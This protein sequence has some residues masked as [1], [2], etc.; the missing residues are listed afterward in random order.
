[1]NM[2]VQFATAVSRF[3]ARLGGALILV[4]AFLVSLDVVF[5]NVFKLAIF[6][7]YELTGYGIALATAFGLSWALV[8]KAHIRIEVLYNML[9]IKPRAYL[10]ICALAALSVVAA[11]LVYYGALVVVDNWELDARSNSTLHVPLAIPQ[12][13]WLLGLAW[14]AVC[15]VVFLLV[16]VSAVARGRHR[17]VQE[18]F[19]IAT[20]SEEVEASMDGTGVKITHGPDVTACASPA[21]AGA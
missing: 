2:S 15:A 9:G 1:M 12:G 21:R 3:L 16:A 17:E 14:F 10:D 13:L 8:T 4:C 20:V 18:M 7:S 5:R 6:E 11:V 19:G